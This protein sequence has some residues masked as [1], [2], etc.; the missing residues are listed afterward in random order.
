ML[1][2]IGV[3]V[4]ALGLAIIRPVFPGCNVI[5]LQFIEYI[6]IPVPR[7]LEG[8]GHFWGVLLYISILEYQVFSS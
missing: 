3:I 2:D 7:C 1:E 8:T 4:M 6:C 5:F